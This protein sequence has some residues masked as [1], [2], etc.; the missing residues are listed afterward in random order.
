MYEIKNILQVGS[1]SDENMGPVALSDLAAA[2]PEKI[3]KFA[4]SLLE[5]LKTLDIDGVYVY[6]Y[7]PG[8]PQVCI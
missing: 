7:F 3:Q 4:V 6:W 1:Y 8:C 2:G 5:I